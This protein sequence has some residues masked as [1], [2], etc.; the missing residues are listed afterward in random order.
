MA[1]SFAVEVYRA[2]PNDT[3]FSVLLADGGFTGL[4]TAFIDGAAAYHTPQ[5]RPERLDQAHASGDG[6]QRARPR[7]RARRPRP[8]RRCRSP[9]AEDATYF[10]VLDRLVRYPGSLVWPLAGAALL[11]VAA[12]SRWSCARRGESSLRRT[13]GRHR[14]GRCCPSCSVRWPSQGLWSLLVA[15][16][17]GTRSMLDPW[18]PGPYRLAAVA[19][20]RRRRA[21]SGTRCCAGGSGRRPWPSAR[22]SGWPCSAAV[23][24]AY[25]PG[26]STWPS[27]PALAGAVAGID[28]R[29]SPPSGIVTR[30]RGAGRRRGGRGGAGAHRRRCSSLRSA[31][32]AARR[33]P[34]W[35]RSWCSLPC[36]RPSSCCSARATPPGQ[37][38]RRRRRAGRRP[39]PRRRVRGRRAVGRHLRREPPGAQPARLRA[40]DDDRDRAWWVTTETAPGAYTAGIRRR[41]PVPARR[42]PLPGRPG[43][44]DRRRRGRRTCPPPWSPRCPTRWSVDGARSPCA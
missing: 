4:N 2:L 1:T 40:Q 21:R 24:A 29:A 37:P 17:P 5:D 8:G 26:G 34:P 3:D 38:A 23:L 25:A 11:A 32:P 28:R 42:L 15:V 31:W 39:G 16:R 33:R 10:P 36:C 19:A 14:A 7:A 41:A 30:D 6:R 9:A 18:R 27:W 20:R 44:P 43:R 35:S 13:A 22:W 12:S